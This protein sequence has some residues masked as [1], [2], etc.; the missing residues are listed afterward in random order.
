M[1]NGLVAALVVAVA[2]TAVGLVVL[3]PTGRSPVAPTSFRVAGAKLSFVKG[4]VV[5]I[6]AGSC[7]QAS[8]SAPAG[9]GCLTVAVHVNGS[10]QHAP[11]ADVTV[12]PGTANPDFA[13]GDE[14]RL[15]RVAVPGTAT[16]YYFDDFV[17]DVPLG[18]LA[19]VFALVVVAVARWRG[20]MALFGLAVAYLVLV[21][22]L[23]PALIRGES[24]VQ[25][26]L[27]SAAAILICVLY[28]VHGPSA[29]TSTALLGTLL[30]LGLT[31]ALAAVAVSSAHLTGLSSDTTSAL[32][33][34]AGQLYYS[35]IILCGVVIGAIGVL[36]DV[37]IT[38]ASAVWELHS[39]D[40]GMPA[41]R[42][43]GSA[44]RIGRDHIASTVYT[45]V[46][47]YAGASLPVLLLFSLS[48]RSAHDVVTGDEVATE[49]VRSLVGGLGLVA[50]VPITTLLATVV[51][52]AADPAKGRDATSL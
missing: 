42:L 17:R 12:V 43:Y 29:R 3:W 37:T 9:S 52:R 33:S 41:R 25:V 28:V 20:V 49:I 27:V 50:A 26:G 5:S 6:T 4:R 47:A 51:V 8:T 32:E 23:L 36:N 1:R 7:G 40:P 38:Q 44:M 46:L 30:S 48:G 22:F 18:W 39:A 2:A 45:L 31:G 19:L 35:G 21:F 14:V 24:P 15:A 11:L 10:S 34:E 13:V 16:V